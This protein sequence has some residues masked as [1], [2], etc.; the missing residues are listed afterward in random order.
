LHSKAGRGSGVLNLR[1][2]NECLLLKHLHKFCN[3][4]NVPWVQLVWD[5]YYYNGWLP[6]LTSS[7]RASFWWKDI[8]K[9]VDSYK[10]MATTNIHNGSSCFFWL[11]LWNG[12]VLQQTSRNYL[13]SLKIHTLQYIYIYIYIYI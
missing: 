1:T 10:D 8:L 9:L 13:P 4:F 11:D 12:R 2:Q 3:Q 5:K 7:F 6:W